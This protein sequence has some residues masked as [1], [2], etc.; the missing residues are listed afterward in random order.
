MNNYLSEML[1]KIL[2][3]FQKM[4]AFHSINDDDSALEIL[5]TVTE[6]EIKVLESIGKTFIDMGENIRHLKNENKTNV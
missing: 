4:E 2:D 5:N 6:E 1:N 3:K